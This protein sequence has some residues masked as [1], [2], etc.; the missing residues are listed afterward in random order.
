MCDKEM[1]KILKEIWDKK[2]SDGIP[3]SSNGFVN[4]DFNVLSKAIENE[5][6]NYLTDCIDL[7]IS[8]N[9]IQFNNVF[10]DHF[11][12]EVIDNSFA[13]VR[14]TLENFPGNYDGCEN[15]YY[16]Q[17]DDQ[18]IALGKYKTL[19][20]SRY[21]FPW[22]KDEINIFDRVNKYWRLIRVLGGRE[23]YSYEHNIPS[24]GIINRI[25]IIQY[26]AGGGTI[27]PHYDPYN[28]Q[29]IN[30]GCV[31]NQYGKDYKE[32]G[33]CT[34]NE[35]DELSFLEHELRKGSLI[36][37][38]PSLFHTVTPIDPTSK[39]DPNSR[40]GRWFMSLLATSSSQAKAK[41]KITTLP[42]P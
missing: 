36:C 27:S 20:G 9:V 25:Q 12:K 8:G 35:R 19:D 5:D 38:F 26:Y 15:Y 21:Y 41:D 39:L 40:K 11:L 2:I 24:D 33:F 29:Y 32:G 18:S 13:F 7:F 30:I 1:Y 31:L 22:N 3:C 23:P 10:E 16:N 37:F 4:E 14:E 28:F 6:I 17:I 42:K 34:F